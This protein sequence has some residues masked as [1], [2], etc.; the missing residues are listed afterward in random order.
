MKFPAL[1]MSELVTVA[2]TPIAIV[3][4]AALVYQSSHAAFSGSTRN[5]GNDWSTGAVSL[6]DDDAGS[7]R[8]QVAN[9]T[10]MQ[11]ETKC[12]RVTANATVPGVVKGYA[13]NPI[14]SPQGLENHI[15]VTVHRGDGGSF[16]TCNNFVPEGP[17]IIPNLTLK[18]IAAFNSFE[19]AVGGWNV[20]PGVHSK[21]Y[22]IKWQF[23]TS[24]LSQT[25]ID[26]LQG[27]RTGIDLQWEMQT[28]S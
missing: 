18:Q 19:A 15:R 1:R 26:Q 4:A 12:I 22:Q 6:T 27:A 9:M 25:Q 2:A 17:A 28:A 5:S 21:T 20:D 14:T 24:Q 13:V 8:F 11:T 16:A 10:P 23:D 7:A 3:A